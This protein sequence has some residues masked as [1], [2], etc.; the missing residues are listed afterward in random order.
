MN[1]LWIVLVV[2][3]VIGGYLW[4]RN[5]KSP[6]ADSLRA[7]FKGK[8]KEAADMVD[9]V[10]N[11]VNSGLLKQEELVRLARTGL[12]KVKIIL[13][14][15]EQAVTTW[16]QKLDQAR[17]DKDLARGKENRDA[18]AAACRDY[19]HAVVMLTTATAA[20]DQVKALVA[21]MEDQVDDQHDQ[22]D[23]MEQ[24]GAELAAAAV[25]DDTNAKVN[26]AKAG[27]T[28]ADGGKNDF[29]KAHEIADKLHARASAATSAAGGLTQ[30]E[31][32]ATALAAL[33]ADV[34]KTNV[35]DEWNRVGD[36]LAS[37]KPEK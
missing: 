32:E 12:Y 26:E 28:K 10:Q 25:V 9:S 23:V 11:R 20:R 3:V 5:S 19:D 14:E 2:V 31:R 22:Q 17:A 37:E 24:E 33:R 18:F 35:D 1:T 27:L 16:Q 7:M 8:E 15:R 4:I 30:R 13:A 36:R 21:G 29:A 6:L 34:K